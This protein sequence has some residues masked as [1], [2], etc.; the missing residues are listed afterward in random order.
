MQ[1]TFFMLMM[2]KFINLKEKDSE[3][4]A[5]PLCVS[6]ISKYFTVDNMTKTRLNIIG[7]NFQLIVILLMLVVLK[8]L[9]NIQ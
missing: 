8:I 5:Y 4:K 1:A 2:Q 6:N 9:I 7:M 3:I